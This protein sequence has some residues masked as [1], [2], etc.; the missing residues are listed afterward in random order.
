MKLIKRVPDKGYI[1]TWLWV[2]K[3][4]VNVEGTKN[5]LSFSFPDSYSEEKVRYLYL[6]RETP[7]HLLVPRA[8]WATKDLPYEVVDCRP[9]SYVQTDVTSRIVLDHRPDEHGVLQ[10]TGDNI[11]EQALN[12]MLL[13]SGGIL[14]LACGKGKTV[15]FLEL[16]AR[17][18]VP[19]LIIVD[20]TH[21]MSQWEKEINAFLDV[22]GG[23]GFI[24]AERNDWKKYIVLATYQ[25]IAARADKLTEEMRRWFG[26]IGWDEGHHISAPTFA[27]GADLFYGKR[28]ALTAT[29]ERPDGTHIVYEFHIGP[30]IYK[31]LSQKITPRIVFKWT[32]MSIDE[33]DPTAN[34]RD[35]NKELHMSKVSSYFGRWR[36]RLQMILSDVHEAKKHGRQKVLVLSNSIG[37][38]VNLLAMYTH[39][40]GTDLYTDIPIPTANDVGEVLPPLELT[41]LTRR[42]KERALQAVKAQLLSATLNPVKR[43]AFEKTRDKLIEELKRAEVQDKVDALL[44][45][46]QRAYLSDLVSS[47]TDAGLMIHDIKPKKRF[48]FVRT[49]RIVFA[50]MKYGKEGLDAP[51][52]DTVIVCEPFSQKNGLQQLMG[53]T[54]RELPGK[55]KPVVVFYEDNVGPIMGMCKKLRTHLQSWPHEEGGPY[56]YELHGHPKVRSRWIANSTV[57]GQ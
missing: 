26:L 39:G 9:R 51:D 45:K 6:W 35:R 23:I 54:T 41:P 36:S 46:R 7:D 3:E 5:A 33:T 13:S 2:P 53:R 20:N 22:P 21:L 29:P 16:A 27:S 57:F 4:H 32:G 44:R 1:D 10:P 8:F 38:I 17:M 18:K 19:T 55:M 12:A 15:V 43:T 37:E 40:D 11:Q 34:V 14:Q 25:T 24:Q 50:I 52:L 31:D 30:V 48:E 28:I 47:T 49:K 56:D 42:K